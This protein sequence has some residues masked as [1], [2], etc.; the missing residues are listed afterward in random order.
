MDNSAHRVSLGRAALHDARVGGGRDAPAA[1]FRADAGER[2]DRARV[3]IPGDVWGC[4]PNDGIPKSGDPES[5]AP[6]CSRHCGM[7]TKPRAG[8]NARFDRVNTPIV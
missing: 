8:Y 6:S 4:F 1:A 2:R 3:V 5:A 7:Y